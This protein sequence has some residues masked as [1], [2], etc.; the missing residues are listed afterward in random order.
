MLRIENLVKV[1]KDVRALDGLN[2]E[3][4]PGQVYGFLGPNG[5]GKSTT[6]LST[7]GLIFP[8]EG[9]IELF[10]EEV[11]R[12]GKFDE[13]QLV[14]AKKRIGYM[15][16]HATLWDFLTPEQTLDI[17][18]D[19]F[20]IPKTEKGKRINE[21]LELVGLKEAR[22]RKV[23][24]FSKGMRQRLLLAQALINDP[25]LLI[26]D[27]PMTGLDPRG[28]AEFKEIIREQ[29]KAGKTVFFSS[30]I[31]AHVEEVCDTVGVIVKG[32]LRVEDSLENIKREFL[33]KAGYTIIIETN[34]PVDW[35]SVEWNVSPLGEN[36]YRVV[37]PE[38]IREELHDF[39]ANQGAKI[40]TMQVKEPSL[41][42]IFLE[43]VG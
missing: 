2:L 36:K 16:E 5:A 15:P 26:L 40:L 42:E 6:I 22:K 10:G 43:M 27:E 25:E 32:K 17:I 39:V 18:A 24:K 1:Y 14:E 8:Q 20:K 9:R 29:R 7:L 38:D 34:K 12:G 41:E 21:L 28:I 4:K 30:H 31:L 35:S 19:A 23:G 33:R 37:A 11:F 3:V 13:N